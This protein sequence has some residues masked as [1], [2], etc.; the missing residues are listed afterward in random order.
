[1]LAVCVAGEGPCIFS[2]NPTCVH[3]VERKLELVA[4]KK[5]PFLASSLLISETLRMVLSMPG[6]FHD[7]PRMLLLL[8]C[9]LSQFLSRVT[10]AVL[11]LKVQLILLLSS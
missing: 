2:L 5:A 10:A 7:S 1:M 8:E 11:I 4:V 6:E 9:F 3:L